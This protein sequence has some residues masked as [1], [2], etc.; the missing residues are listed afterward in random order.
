LGVE[1]L[2]TNLQ[3]GKAV[4]DCFPVDHAMHADGIQNPSWL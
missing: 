4:P 1:L 3:R 2:C